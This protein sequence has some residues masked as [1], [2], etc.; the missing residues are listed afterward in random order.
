VL[1]LFLPVLVFLFS[2]FFLLQLKLCILPS[3]AFDL[4]LEAEL[5][6][7]PPS[8]QVDGK[9]KLDITVDGKPDDFNATVLNDDLQTAIAAEAGV[10][11]QDDIDKLEAFSNAALLP[12]GQSIK[13]A[14][15]IPEDQADESGPDLLAAL[16]FEP[17]VE[18]RVS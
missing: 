5:E 10:T 15:D 14:S 2:L 11:A 1:K 18:V 13:A 12:V 7:L 17:R 4:K 6:A 16:E 8:F 3:V 9:F